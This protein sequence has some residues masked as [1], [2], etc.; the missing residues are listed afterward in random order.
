M[1]PDISKAADK[2]QDCHLK[3]QQHLLLDD[4][5]PARV[6]PVIGLAGP[7]PSAAAPVPRRPVAPRKPV[8][9]RPVCSLPPAAPV[10]MRPPA[11]V[12]TPGRP[13]CAVRTAC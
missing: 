3:P 6:L 5:N 9:R 10:A 12:R 1:T 4:R 2:P 11:V 8:P 7:E 13:P